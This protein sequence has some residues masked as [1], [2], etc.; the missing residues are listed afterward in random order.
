VS[1]TIIIILP[2]ANL[3][4][5][6]PTTTVACACRL[7]R[8]QSCLHIV[9]WKMVNFHYNNVCVYLPI[10]NMIHLSYCDL[11]FFGVRIMWTKYTNRQRSTLLYTTLTLLYSMTFQSLKISSKISKK[12]YLFIYLFI[13]IVTEHAMK[14]CFRLF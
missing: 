12:N 5:I 6:I 2:A 8:L 9:R 11:I 14:T 1:T 10:P 13:V 7:F 3:I 4:T